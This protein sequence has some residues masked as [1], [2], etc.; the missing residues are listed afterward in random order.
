MGESIEVLEDRCNELL[1]DDFV[2]ASAILNPMKVCPSIDKEGGL[3][4]TSPDCPPFDDA[5]SALINLY[6]LHVGRFSV[7]PSTELQDSVLEPIF[8]SELS[9]L[10]TQMYNPSETVLEFWSRFCPLLP[11]LHIVASILS[12]IKPS[13]VDCERIFSRAKKFMR[14]DRCRLEPTSLDKCLFLQANSTYFEK[15][16]RLVSPNWRLKTLDETDDNEDEDEDED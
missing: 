4:T 6:K 16:L 12:C 8:E 1:K 2:I 10:K 3:V 11:H 5:K 7:K 15:S 13:S 14:P 9:R